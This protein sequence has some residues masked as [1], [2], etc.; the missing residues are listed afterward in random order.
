MATKYVKEFSRNY[1]LFQIVAYGEFAKRSDP[2]F[3]TE[4]DIG[5]PLFIYRGGPLTDIYFPPGEM[6][7]V[8]AD[9]GKALAN[10][11]YF[12]RLVQGSSAVVKEIQPYFEKKK[13]AGDLDELRYLYGLYLDFLYGESAS[14]V[15]PHIEELPQ[16]LRSRAMSI[17]EKSQHLSSMRDEMFDFNLRELFPELGDYVHFLTPASVFGGKS[18]A[19]LKAEGQKYRDGFISLDGAFYVG[20]QEELLGKLGI[21]L[22]IVALETD[23]VEITGQV[24][25]PGT[26]RGCVKIVWTKNDNSK[27]MDGDILVSPMTRPDF[28]PAMKA[29]AAFVTD[30]GGITCHAAIVSREMMKP[31]V[32]GTKIATKVLHDG[33]EVEVNADKGIV[34]ILKRA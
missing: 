1:S 30:E 29:A 14:W 8:Y 2:A 12:E 21:E 5:H 24:A 6:K 23:I 7:R 11:D 26:A 16:E 22:E 18:A 31:C 9:F 13:K 20:P 27:I 28:L 34:R 3:N 25:S 19:E 33:D 32:I 4:I 17:R 10:V 15:A